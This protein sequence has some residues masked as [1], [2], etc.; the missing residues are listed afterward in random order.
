MRGVVSQ[1]APGATLPP[2]H[3]GGGASSVTSVPITALHPQPQAGG[4]SS[5]GADSAPSIPAL[6]GQA[7]DAP[8]A[9]Q[10]RPAAAAAVA[11]AP[12]VAESGYQPSVKDIIGSFSQREKAA[13][14]AALPL[15]PK[16][17]Q[18]LRNRS[19]A[20]VD[21][22]T[23]GGKAAPLQAGRDGG[24]RPLDAKEEIEKL[25]TRLQSVELA[26]EA[27]NFEVAT[28]RVRHI[29]QH[30]QVE[31]AEAARVQAEHARAVAALDLERLGRKVTTV[32]Q[33]AFMEGEPAV[34]A[35]PG[36]AKQQA[37]GAAPTPDH[38]ATIGADSDAVLG[39][40]IERADA[41]P[42]ATTATAQ[43]AVQDSSFAANMSE[44][45]GNAV[46]PMQRNGLDG[47][48]PATRGEGDS[49]EQSSAPAAPQVS[50][51]AIS[52]S[53]QSGVPTSREVALAALPIAQAG[54]QEPWDGDVHEAGD[55]TSL[56][57]LG[58]E[59]GLGAL[60]GEDGKLRA[61]KAAAHAAD[62][63]SAKSGAEL[64]SAAGAERLAQDAVDAQPWQG[65]EEGKHPGSSQVAEL[66]AANAALRCSL[67]DVSLAA[68][69]AAEESRQC[70]ET[71]QRDAADLKSRLEEAQTEADQLRGEVAAL[72]QSLEGAEAA[73]RAA[74]AGADSAHTR[75][76]EELAAA[77]V[78]ALE[79]QG[80][81]HGR[82]VEGLRMEHDGAQRALAAAHGEEVARMQQSHVD[83]LEVLRREH[84]D[85]VSG[86]GAAHAQELSGVQQS[87][88]GR[89]EAL[90]A[91][92]RGTAA[93]HGEEVE[94]IQ[95]RHAHAIAAL[96]AEHEKLV[97]GLREELAARAQEGL[98]MAAVLEAARKDAL[99]AREHGREASSAKRALELS[100]D[101]L[102]S[103]VAAAEVARDTVVAEAATTRDE[104]AAG[105]H[106]LELAQAAC[107]ARESELRKKRDE[108]E[109][110][111]VECL[112]LRQ[113]LEDSGGKC[114]AALA[115]AAAAAAEAGEARVE[116]RA[117]QAAAA[118]AESRSGAAAR[119]CEAA[120]AS[121]H[122]LLQRCL[123]AEAA[124]E[125]TL[126]AGA[127]SRP[128]LDHSPQ[129]NGEQ[130]PQEPTTV[131]SAELNAEEWGRKLNEV[132]ELAEVKVAA[133]LLQV[134]AAQAAEQESTRKAQAA[135]LAAEK[136]KEVETTA[137]EEL[138]RAKE[139]EA[140]HTQQQEERER[141]AAAAT[142]AAVA[143]LQWRVDALERA[144]ALLVGEIQKWR[145]EAV[146]RRRAAEALQQRQREMELA[147]EAQRL[148]AP[149]ALGG[150]IPHSAVFLSELPSSQ[151]GGPRSVPA[152]PVKGFSG[153]LGRSGAD[154]RAAANLRLPFGWGT[155]AAR[156]LRQEVPIR[157]TS[158]GVVPKTVS[159]VVGD[160]GRRTSSG[161]IPTTM[162]DVGAG[163]GTPTGGKA[164]QH[165][166]AASG[167][168]RRG[169]PALEHGG[170][171]QEEEIT[172][173]HGEGRSDEAVRLAKRPKRSRVSKLG[174]E[175][176]RRILWARVK[177]FV[178]GFKDDPSPGT[179][180][181]GV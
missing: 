99:E 152:T 86:Q 117:A 47:G 35:A 22:V 79:K 147:L 154:I 38:Q 120:K 177:S 149:A 164:A 18:E 101:G 105:K 136:A 150:S 104:L 125:R 173:V 69:G 143:M 95:R 45:A 34:E 28:L 53:S 25:L 179:Q 40:D 106:A 139:R 175:I 91:E 74:L 92:Q 113:E 84:E 122:A 32:P 172:E 83:G 3:S 33:K 37:E 64:S 151:R 14:G 81:E 65:V 82:A 51:A 98:G 23:K 26:L 145:Q 72:E 31:R 24:P 159:D 142:T 21:W 68:A 124:L 118:T 158:S 93:A 166:Q 165:M 107:A 140:A 123:E 57:L 59:A 129:A 80:L 54:A 115:T 162:S 75:A 29:E 13:G 146:V 4:S 78:V 169:R 160:G 102:Q 20:F 8:R 55:R 43:S 168:E 135:E 87:H 141:S 30:T 73:H 131:R 163:F 27:A 161:V 48:A 7:G 10:S 100:V 130:A 63:A 110:L 112:Q 176:E 58:A 50:G 17:A 88:T 128:S 6:R 171:L 134:R 42:K 174:G 178:Q 97:A 39:L 56:K 61:G 126:A 77:H 156:S 89:L 62:E 155:Q 144:K 167:G 148:Q 121:E 76:L 41:G 137:T 36:P 9:R 11:V 5:S 19:A 90:Q 116:A 66:E 157:R 119:A 1:Q 44:S 49:S 12:A 2:V 111:S 94:S 133:A 180:A 138:A 52:P 67:E 109:A 16:S 153:P 103:Q 114:A 71:A 108:Y 85:E 181:A 96:Q 127:A 46:L 170:Y 60:D 70:L 15:A 132:Q